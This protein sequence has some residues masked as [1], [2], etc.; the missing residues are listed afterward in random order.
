MVSAAQPSPRQHIRQLNSAFPT[1]EVTPATSRIRNGKE[2]P[3]TLGNK[4]LDVYLLYLTGNVV[5]VLT[6]VKYCASRLDGSTC[7]VILAFLKSREGCIFPDF[8]KSYFT[9][10]G[11]THPISKGGLRWRSRKLTATCCIAA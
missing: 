4:Q 5:L 3:Q 1:V 6:K 7:F 8:R 10:D 11:A 2:S 9:P